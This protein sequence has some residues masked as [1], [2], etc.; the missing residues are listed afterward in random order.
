MNEEVQRLSIMERSSNPKTGDVLI[1]LAALIGVLAR[2]DKVKKSRAGKTCVVQ[3]LTIQGR[4]LVGSLM[5]S[6]GPRS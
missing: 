4:G 1:G 6:S 3:A 2:K 5:D